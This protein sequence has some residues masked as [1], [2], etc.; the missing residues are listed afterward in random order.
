MFKTYED[1]EKMVEKYYEY[2]DSTLSKLTFEILPETHGGENESDII[3]DI[4]FLVRDESGE[5]ITDQILETRSFEAD[6]YRHYEMTVEANE[7][8]FD[9]LAHFWELMEA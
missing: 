7:I 2:S 5:Y 8:A 9:L 6:D 4:C 1:V 3:Q